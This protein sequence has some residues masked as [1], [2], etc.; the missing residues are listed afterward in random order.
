YKTKTFRFHA[1]D[2][3]IYLMRDGG[4]RRLTMD[5]S[6]RESGNQ[7]NAPTNM[8]TNSLG[9]GK[10]TF[11]EFAEIEQPFINN[12]IY[13]LCSD[14]LHGIVSVGDIIDALLLPETEPNEAY[15][16][17]LL[18]LA[19]AAGGKDNISIIT[20]KTCNAEEQL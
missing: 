12:D 14:G 4:L 13:L 10:N 20:I 7:P 5:H 19:K 15:A 8:I 2:S 3:R 17:K 11:I 16:K 1:G 18:A 6:L 9:G